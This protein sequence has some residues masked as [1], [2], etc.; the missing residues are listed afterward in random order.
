MSLNYLVYL[1]NESVIHECSFP[2]H[3]V[4]CSSKYPLIWLG[5]V[6]KQVDLS[7]LMRYHR[8]MYTRYRNGFE[9]GSSELARLFHF[10]DMSVHPLKIRCCYLDSELEDPVEKYSSMYGDRFI[11]K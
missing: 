1:D 10:N 5:T 4:D 11:C 2:S 6:K 7:M 8:M 9:W 3:V